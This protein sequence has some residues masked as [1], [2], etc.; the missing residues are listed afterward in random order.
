[1][2]GL[3][4]AGLLKMVVA[5][6]FYNTLY[7]SVL[8]KDRVARFLLSFYPQVSYRTLNR[9]FRFLMGVKPVLLTSASFGSLPRFS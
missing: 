6:V 1:M 3:T 2:A 4:V 9:I 8:D 7:A 5:F